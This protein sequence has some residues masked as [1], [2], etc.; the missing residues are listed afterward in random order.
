MP[1]IIASDPLHYD[2]QYAGGYHYYDSNGNL[3][4]IILCDIGWYSISYNCRTTGGVIDNS[5]FECDLEGGYYETTDSTMIFRSFVDET[6]LSYED[7]I[8]YIFR[9]VDTLN[10][11]IIFTKNA[12]FKEGEFIHR[13][14]YMPPNP[15]DSCSSSIRLWDIF[16]SGKKKSKPYGIRQYKFSHSRN[17][18]DLY[19]FDRI[20]YL[21]DTIYKYKE[22][23]YR[24]HKEGQYRKH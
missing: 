14:S 4:N 7:K 20:K 6:F 23:Q 9:I 3:Y 11:E 12:F 15:N 19:K 13:S 21:P 2:K 1:N 22:G 10:L 8:S 18:I 24:K 16:Y 17:G 5:M